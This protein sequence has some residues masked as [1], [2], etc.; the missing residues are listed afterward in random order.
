MDLWGWWSRHTPPAPPP[1][2][3]A[4]PALQHAQ[5]GKMS[6]FPLLVTLCLSLVGLLG[7]L[8]SATPV[9]ALLAAGSCIVCL[10]LLVLN[11]RGKSLLVGIIIWAALTAALDIELFHLA[12]VSPS[13][14]P[15]FDLLVGNELLAALLLPL[16]YVLIGACWNSVFALVALALLPH[17]P[18]LETVIAASAAQLSLWSLAL[19]VLVAAGIWLLVWM[20]EQMHNGEEVVRLQQALQREQGARGHLEAALCEMEDS[21]IRVL[22]G[23]LSARSRVLGEEGTALWSVSCSLNDLLDRLQRLAQVEASHQAMLPL[24]TRQQE[25]QDMQTALYQ[26]VAQAILALRL[27]EARGQPIQPGTPCVEALSPL[28]R[29]LHQNYLTRRLWS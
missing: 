5:R 20:G 8:I 11:Q 7:A 26:D 16:P 1:P 25:L 18:F 22:G 15:L 14:I 29:A 12:T 19:Y 10:G 3:A 2:G 28:F 21:A 6:S 4:L 23:D 17:A 24:L 9:F 27:A 13:A